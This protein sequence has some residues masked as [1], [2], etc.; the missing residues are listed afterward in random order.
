MPIIA[1][2]GPKESGKSTV[3]RWLV[4]NRSATEVLLAGELKRVARL[5]FPQTV[6][7]ADID[8]PSRARERKLTSAQ[9][10]VAAGELQAAA[11]FLRTDPDGRELVAKLFAPRRTTAAQPS[12]VLPSEAANH[13]RAVFADTEVVFDTPRKV[14]QF[15]GTEWGR[16]IW[17]EVW[18]Y[19]VQE[20]VTAAPAKL[21]V[22]PD[23]RFPNEAAYLRDR[24]GA[25]V[26]WVNAGDRIPTSRDPHSSEPTRDAL[27][28]FLVGDIDT[29]GTLADQ[30]LVLAKLF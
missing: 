17:D 30:P 8:G 3:A 25:K 29:S 19:V 16:K 18:L 10:R 12:A 23:C 5:F 11:T 4:E 13:L 1:L 21:W 28:P 7:Q 15:L 22:I 27:S 6:T 20:T 9:K 24:L 26:Y 2:A 14:L